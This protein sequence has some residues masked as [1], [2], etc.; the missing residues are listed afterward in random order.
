MH[1]AG[2]GD[3]DQQ[4]ALVGW[5]RWADAITIAPDA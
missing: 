3:F 4:S 2:T 5:L 1:Q